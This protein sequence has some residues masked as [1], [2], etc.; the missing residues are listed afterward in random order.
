MKAIVFPSPGK[1]ELV[2]VPDPV[3]GPDEA[4]IEVAVSGICGTDLHVNAGDYGGNFPLIPG[5]EFSG[6]VVELGRDVQYLQLG[7]RVTAD[8]NVLCT[9]CR[10]C[11]ND[12]PNH[13][14]NW[15]GLGVSLNG[16]FAEYVKVPARNCHHVP[17][18]LSDSQAAFIEPLACVAYALRR[19]RVWPG[20]RVLIFGAGPM[21]LLLLQALQHGGASKVVIV[22]KVADRLSAAERFGAS[23]A[24]LAGPDQAS[25]LTDLAP[26]GFN[27]VIDATGVPAVIEQAFNYLAP[28]GQFLQF[29]VA[30]EEA[31]VRISPAKFF[32][33][34][35]VM[36]GSFAV[37]LSFEPAI[38]WLV[39]GVIDTD[40]LVS[41]VVPLEE[42]EDVFNQVRD[43]VVLKGHVR[44]AGR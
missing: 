1:L 14:Q 44:I 18:S 3:C 4:V 36:L 13:C 7:D 28:R 35:W 38:D 17:D 37:C 26:Y 9:H 43:G 21:G 27:V 2:D 22:E 6:T 10:F 39:N 11:R 29:G 23:S 8:P 34:D 30:P 41:E 20:D 19:L 32:K 40:P 15:S 33:K 5:H 25:V 42:F 31:M 24:V 16:S 12:Q